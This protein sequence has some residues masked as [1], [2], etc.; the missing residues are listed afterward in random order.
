MEHNK[1]ALA[2]TIF[3]SDMNRIVYVNILSVAVHLKDFT[4][5]Y[6]FTLFIRIPG[7]SKPVNLRIVFS[8]FL[9][10]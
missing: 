2:S 6:F 3:C 7:A 4:K 8:Y 10:S 5:V 9:A 1:I